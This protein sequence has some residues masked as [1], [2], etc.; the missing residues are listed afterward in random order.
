MLMIVDTKR[1]MHYPLRAVVHKEEE[2]GMREGGFCPPGDVWQSLETLLVV[3]LGVCY[4][5]QVGRGQGHC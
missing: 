5:Q 3:T 1:W 2:G 4:C